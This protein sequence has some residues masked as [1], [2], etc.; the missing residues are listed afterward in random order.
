MMRPGKTAESAGRLLRGLGALTANRLLG[1]RSAQP[2]QL[3]FKTY[4][5]GASFDQPIPRII[6][7]YWDDE[8]LPLLVRMCV[9]NI[10]R[11]NPGFAVH[12]LHPGNV[13][14][15]VSDIPNELWK[16][17][18]QKQT[19]W[20]RLY[21]LKV[22]GGIWIDASSVVTESFEWV[23]QVQQQYRSE[24]VG[25]YIDQF[26]TKPETPILENW[27]IAAVPGSPF[28]ANWLKLISDE[29]IAR[30]TAQCFERLQQKDYYADLVQ[31]ITIPDYLVMHLLGQEL[32]QF[33]PPAR[34]ALARAEDCAFFYHEAVS[35][36]LKALHAEI[37]FKPA[38]GRVPLF[39]KLRGGDR[40][41]LE[42]YLSTGV[43]LR[44]SVV[45]RAMGGSRQS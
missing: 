36:R 29:V 38:A 25:F 23:L 21:L 17:T 11:L 37:L 16:H 20:F 3:V 7:L 26:T 42:R 10:K 33:G 9:E 34:F 32:M 2:P 6:W 14:E 31:G 28:I 40:P 39:V 13:K 35:W 41:Y 5:K 30:G 19:D 4:G 45:G 18:V 24:L 22:H 27:F 44:D 15:F 8:Q 12:L 43:Y 1:R